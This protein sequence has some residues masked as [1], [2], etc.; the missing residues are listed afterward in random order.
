MTAATTGRFVWHELHTTDRAKAVKFY[1]TLIGWETKDVNMGPGEPYT[2]CLLNG[3]D[4]AG[5]TKSMAPPE[6]PPHWVPYIACDDVDAFLAK[7]EKLGGKALSKPM[8]IPD[9][10]RFAA[11]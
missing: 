8:D 10:G 6:I 2:L 7:A 1:S 5:I 4:H 3:K 11:V 9:Q